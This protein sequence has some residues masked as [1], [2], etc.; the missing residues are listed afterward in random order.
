MNKHLLM[1]NILVLLGFIAMVL[2]G[3]DP[4]GGVFLI[5]PGSILLAFGAWLARPPERWLAYAAFI[6][7]TVSFAIVVVVSQLG[8]L[9]GSAPLLHSKWWG[10]LLLPYPVGWTMGVAGGAFMLPHLF[11]GRW[12][13]VVSII[14]STA[15]FVFLVR[16]STFQLVPW[17][18][19]IA[20]VLLC[21]LCIFAVLKREK[22]C[23]VRKG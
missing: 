6:L 16:L 15:A 22:A 1:A 11:T 2:G 21:L 23:S 14:G 5:F 4:V 18:I 19:F 12:A 3:I 10:L 7:M 20:V 9:G 8:G 13:R 17:W